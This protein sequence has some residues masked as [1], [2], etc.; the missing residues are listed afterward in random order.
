M[1][2][3]DNFKGKSHALTLED[4]RRGGRVSSRK[5]ALANGLKN[6]K[7]GKYSNNHHYLLC[8][9]DCPAIGRCEKMSD[10]YCYYLLKEMKINRDFSKQVARCLT[11]K[12]DDIDAVSFLAKKYKLNK[13]Y[14]SML[15]P[16]I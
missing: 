16:T 10:G 1:N 7:H 11:V 14:I 8:C 9:I 3:L 13:D 6:L 5:K 12:K 2:R 15:F 4:R